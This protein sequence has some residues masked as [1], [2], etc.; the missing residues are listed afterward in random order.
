MF[1]FQRCI[2]ITPEH[3]CEEKN[4]I[5]LNTSAHASEN[6]TERV[7]IYT[8][9][10]TSRTAHRSAR[11]NR[12]RSMNGSCSCSCNQ[13]EKRTISTPS[14]IN[15]PQKMSVDPLVFFAQT[16]FQSDLLFLPSGLF[17]FYN[18]VLPVTLLRLQGKLLRLPELCHQKTVRI[19]CS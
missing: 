3:A 16:R 11:T 10:G 5:E 15:S 13:Q 8:L 18:R 19:Y 4:F 17:T 7:F 2:Q 1:F 9:Y 12:R 14:R 6:C